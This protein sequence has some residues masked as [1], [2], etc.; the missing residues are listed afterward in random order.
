MTTRE[1]YLTHQPKTH[2]EPPKEPAVPE[3]NDPRN[4]DVTIHHTVTN[5]RL[6]R[7]QIYDT[8]RLTLGEELRFT[9][10]L[11]LGA[12]ETV[13]AGLTPVAVG[14]R[15]SVARDRSD[16]RG[17]GT[18]VYVPRSESKQYAVE[19]DYPGERGSLSKRYLSGLRRLAPA[20]DPLFHPELRK[21]GWVAPK[22]E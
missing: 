6:V 2:E 3:T 14:D 17:I 4:V 1:T 19:L 9:L 7:D 21:R 5:A 12:L 13:L 15:V 20:D 11:Y 10:K 22:A 18:V 16:H 8:D